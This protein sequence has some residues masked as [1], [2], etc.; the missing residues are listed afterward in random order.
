[1]S[2]LSGKELAERLGV[3]PSKIRR[4]VKSGMPSRKDG[5]RRVYDPAKVR[6]WLVANGLAQDAASEPAERIYRTRTECAKAFG[7]NLRT[8]AQWMTEPGFPGQAGTPGQRDGCFPHAAIEAWLEAKRANQPVNQYSGAAADPTR[9]ELARIKLEQER[10]KLNEK[11]GR[12]V[13]VDE[14]TRELMR[15]SAIARQTLRNLPDM[16]VSVLPPD[17]DPRIRADF[18]ARASSIVDHACQTI[19]DHIV[20]EN[21]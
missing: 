2:E 10:L 19:A 21:G 16:L 5:R 7:V 4:W 11:Q 20:A 13:D 17:I 3:S 12:F 14:V 15:L 6:D 9:Q 18:K 8:V 1:M